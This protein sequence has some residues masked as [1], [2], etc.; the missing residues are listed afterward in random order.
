[1]QSNPKAAKSFSWI[2]A[3]AQFIF[4]SIL[5]YNLIVFSRRYRID[6]SVDDGKYHEGSYGTDQTAIR[7]TS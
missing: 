6:D 5:S 1:M 2:V 7:C 3:A 4:F